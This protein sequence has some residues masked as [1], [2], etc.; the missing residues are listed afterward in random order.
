[1]QIGWRAIRRAGVWGE[2]Q[3]QAGSYHR[4]KNAGRE[5]SPSPSL[6]SKIKYKIGVGVTGEVIPTGRL[7]G[8]AWGVAGKGEGAQ[9]NS[10]YPDP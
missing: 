7:R 10:P 8:E 4:W 9:T 2:R 1:M 3:S 5:G 6:P